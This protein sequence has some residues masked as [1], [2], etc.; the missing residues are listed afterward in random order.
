MGKGL[1]NSLVDSLKGKHISF[2][3]STKDQASFNP[4]TN[5]LQW[6]RN[7]DSNQLFHELMHAYQY[8]NEK[9]FDSWKNAIINMEIETHYAHY[10][11]IKGSSEYGGSDWEKGSKGGD[12]RILSIIHLEDYVDN[13]GNLIDGMIVDLLDTYLEF[14]VVTAFKQDANYGKYSY[15]ESRSSLSNFSNL[16]KITKDC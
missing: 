16:N 2:Q 8:Q 5:M 13:K 11:Y 10:L 3:F 7:M 9:S 6:N 12:S 14:H 1:Y 15:D 4:Q